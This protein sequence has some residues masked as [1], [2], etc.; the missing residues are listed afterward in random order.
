MAVYMYLAT[1]TL[2]TNNR[3]VVQSQP[4]QNAYYVPLSE[5]L[6]VFS[7]KMYDF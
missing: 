6:A 2:L 7:W 1:A 3:Q 5:K 4:K